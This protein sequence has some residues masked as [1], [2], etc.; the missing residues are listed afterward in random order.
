M[1]LHPDSNTN[2]RRDLFEPNNDTWIKMKVGKP[3]YS[4]T[5][6]QNYGGIMDRRNHG[7]FLI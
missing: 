6:E 4:L 1:Y 2:K 7:H 3:V 5:Q